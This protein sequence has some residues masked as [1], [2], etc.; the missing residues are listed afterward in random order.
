MT[1]KEKQIEELARLCCLPCKN[2]Y[3]GRCTG[4]FDLGRCTAALNTAGAIY[5]TGYRK[6][7][8]WI[9]VDERLPERQGTYLVHTVKGAIKFGEF[10]SYLANDEPQFDYFVTHWMPLPEPPKM[11]GGESDAE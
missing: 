2:E 10:R 1:D 5:N 8:G 6:Q 11:K 7:S 9:S 4:G 3:C